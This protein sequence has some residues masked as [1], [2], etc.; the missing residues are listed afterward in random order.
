MLRFASVEARA[1]D[2]IGAFPKF[3]EGDEGWPAI[4]TSLMAIML[5][6]HP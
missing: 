6:V 3:D 1:A 5:L 2:T 4:K